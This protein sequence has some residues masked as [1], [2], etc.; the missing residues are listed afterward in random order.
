MRLFSLVTVLLPT[1]LWLCGPVVADVEIR[2]VLSE[3]RVALVVGNSAYTNLPPLRNPANDAK[4]IAAALRDAGFENVVQAENLTRGELEKA[5]RAFEEQLVV[6]DWAVIYFAG[7]G[8]DINGENYILPIDADMSDGDS[9][10]T[11]LG[12]V[13]SISHLTRI[14]GRARKLGIVFV[15]ACRD[16]HPFVS[17]A[18]GVVSGIAENAPA[19]LEPAAP[20]KLGPTL[21]RSEGSLLI[22]YAGQSGHPV[23]DGVGG[24]SPFAASLVKRL[25]E[26]HLEVLKLLRLLR[27]DVLKATDG[28]QEPAF[29]ASLAGSEDYYFRP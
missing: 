13:A 29:Y 16:R 19:R 12:E 14:V 7:S 2:P 1:F 24:N 9:A 22:V 18:R 21:P 17:G 28:A 4:S 11:S 20:V 26:P 10:S 5:L 27:D 15:D 6:A 8:V 3:N 23:L 25:Y